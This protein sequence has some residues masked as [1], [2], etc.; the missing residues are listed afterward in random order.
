MADNVTLPATGTGTSTPVI[1]SDDIGS[2]VQA[3]RIKI[4]DGTD[5][6]AVGVPGGTE[7]LR[8]QGQVDADAAVAGKPVLEGGRASDAIP[9]AVSA[10]GDSVHA[11]N[12]RRGARKVVL[13]DD[14]GNSVMDGVSDAVRVNVVTGSAAA[15]EYQEGTAQ[16]TIIGQAVLWE[17]TGDVVRAASAAKPFPVSIISGSSSNTEYT[18]GA[19]DATITGGVVMWEDTSD[20]IR[21]ASAANPFPVEVISSPGGSVLPDPVVNSSA[22]AVPIKFASVNATT[23]GDNTVIAAVPTKKLRILGYVLTATGAGTITLKSA[24]AGAIGRIICSANGA[25]ASYPGGVDAPACETVAGEAF[26]INNPVGVDTM[27]H[28]SYIEI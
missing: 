12:D 16:V 17:D 3:Q 20:T 2:G 14:A 27:G 13:V 4:L 9:S 26:V 25:G 10:D 19:V 11:W 22:V 7:G 24:T 23:D 21:A 5:G 8:T 6:S 1:A 15:T 28:L 18:E